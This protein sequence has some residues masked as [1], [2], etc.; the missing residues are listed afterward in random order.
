[1]NNPNHLG[2]HKTHCCILHGCKYG[3]PDCPVVQ[4]V[5]VQDYLCEDCEPYYNPWVKSSIEVKIEDFKLLK[6]GAKN[7]HVFEK[8]QY[9]LVIGQIVEFENSI[10]QEKL[11]KIVSLIEFKEKGLSSEMFIACF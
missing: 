5:I 3:D 8:S 10:D 1:M 6:T 7:Y 2:A 4:R 11:I 9:T